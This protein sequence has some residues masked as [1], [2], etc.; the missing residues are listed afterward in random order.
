MMH[1]QRAPV[2]RPAVPRS[3]PLAAA[4][5][6]FDRAA[7]VLHLEPAVRTVLRAPRREWTVHFPVERDDG[8]V[9]IFTG[10]RVHHNLARGP[11]KGGIRYHPALT[12]DEARALA[13]AMTWKCALTGLPFGGAKG[14][15]ACDPASLS[16]HELERL[17]RRFTIEL[18]GIIGPE[19]DIPAPD[20]GTDARV[21]AWMLDAYE[22]QHGAAAPNVVTGKPVALGGLPERG[23]ATGRGVVSTIQEAAQRIDL[24]LTGARIAIQGFGA[25]GAAVARLLHQLGARIVA[26]TDV[27]GGVFHGEGLNPAALQR[28]LEEMGSVAGAPR[29]EPIDNAALIRLDCDVL[30]PAALGGQIT[31][32]IAEE[33][34]ARLLAEAANGPTLPEADPV[35]RD[36]GV[37]VIP[38]LLCNAGGVTVSAFEWAQHRTGY[39]WTPVERARRLHRILAGAFDE[40]WRLAADQAL[41]TRL[42]A[43]VLAVGRVAEATR[44]RGLAA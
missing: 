10:Y 1:D 36:R 9:Q 3:S 18:G 20:V 14:G 5:A 13:M 39:G 27:G 35:L 31:A 26:V 15:V 6:S 29:T 2:A 19:R 41:D 33:V 38:D 30:V 32:A 37:V 7:D 24:E 25:V 21:M 17:T 42:A 4:L 34:R 44:L 11:A 28:H 16:A 22:R 40:V 12:L 23:E 43:H 8:S